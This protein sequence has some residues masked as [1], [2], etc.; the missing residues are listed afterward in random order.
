MKNRI[1][2]VLAYFGELPNYN[3]LFLKSCLNQPFDLIFFT[4]QNLKEKNNI[5]VVKLSFDDFKSIIQEKF[6]FSISLKM[7]YKF[8]DFQPAIGYI[9]NDYLKSYDFWGHCDN[10]QI[11]GDFS[12]FITDE[13]LDKYD[14]L[15]R[16]GHLT[17][18]R[19]SESNNILFMNEVG[20]DYK[21]V[22]SKDYIFVF[23]E[24]LGIQKK[25]EILGIPTYQANNYFDIGFK[26]YE[27]KRVYYGKNSKS[28]N[29][30]HQVFYYE[31]GKIF[32]A[33]INDIGEIEVEEGLYLHFQKRKPILKMSNKSLS[34]FI[35]P[36]C[37]L[38][39]NYEGLPSREEIIFFS[40]KHL[41]K[42]IIS[43]FRYFGFIWKR[44][45]NKY[46]LER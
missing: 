16:C 19:N 21:K 26:S 31:K 36:E 27:M 13:I 32:R 15:Y 41:L 18:Y 37:I 28:I 20:M 35:L 43:S 40:K 14:K 17:I 24:I 38:K 9:F 4:D 2:I 46:I 11:F 12:H 1:A 39:K 29:H 7:P 23:D 3:D 34:F 45:F 10:D 42:E 30:K 44:R 8:V 22:F 5:K 6:N 25:F 33:Y